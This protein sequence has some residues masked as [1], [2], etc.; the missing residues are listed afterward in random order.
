[1]SRSKRTSGLM[2]LIKQVIIAKNDYSEV[3][4][5]F[6]QTTLTNAILYYQNTSK[7]I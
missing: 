3:Y 4:K 5:L 6:P 2:E 1:M 7:K